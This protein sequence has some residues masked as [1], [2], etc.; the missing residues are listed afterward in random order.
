MKKVL[1]R[2]TTSAF[3]ATMAMGGFVLAG[4]GS[5]VITPHS[6]FQRVVNAAEK[7]QSLSWNASGN[8]KEEDGAIL[9]C[10][11]IPKGKILSMKQTSSL[12][13]E[14]EPLLW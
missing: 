14:K 5:N 8:Y 2:V 3:A 12:R 4:N 11:V 7:S 1:T 10:L 6:A 9:F 13:N